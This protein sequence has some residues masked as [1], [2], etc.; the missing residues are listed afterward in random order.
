MQPTTAVTIVLSSPGDLVKE[1]LIVQYAIAKLDKLFEMK[2]VRISLR[3]W[4][5][6]AP[7]F[8]PGGLQERIEQELGISNCDLLIALFWRRYGKVDEPPYSRTAREVLAA[9]DSKRKRGKPEVMV[10][11]SRR[12]YFPSSTE[13]LREQIRVLEFKQEL[14]DAGVL[15]KDF[16]LS[17][18]G[19]MIEYDTQIYF[20]QALKTESVEGLT[21]SINCVPLDVRSEG[22]TEMTGA[23]QIDVTGTIS[24]SPMVDIIASL[25]MNVTN[26]MSTD[27]TVDA[28]VMSRNRGELGRGRIAGQ[29][30][31]LLFSGISL[32]PPGASI[33]DTLTIYGI[34]VDA[35]FLGVSRSFAP[36]KILASVQIRRTGQSTSTIATKQLDVAYVNPFTRISLAPLTTE[37]GQVEGLP[38]SSETETR[39]FEVTFQ[40]AFPGAFAPGGASPDERGTILAVALM[41]LPEDAIAL[42][43]ITDVEPVAPFTASGPGESAIAVQST[44][45]GSPL[46][47]LPKSEGARWRGSLPMY[48]IKAGL[49]I[50]E[51]VRAMPGGTST[52]TFGLVLLIPRSSL[53]TA[54][55]LAGSLAP[56]FSTALAGQP[57][58]TLPVPRFI[59]GLS[60][61]DIPIE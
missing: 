24:S 54:I 31:T 47:G 52:V 29:N 2:G 51:L 4:E 36:A 55:T 48:R 27:G 45:T 35:Q 30:N 11:F 39:L 19:E 33:N 44:A 57:S 3:K 22:Y 6:L 1:R 59:P 43:T 5:D 8:S 46:T 12:P 26:R 38:A 60:Q 13:E 42:A 37:R 61:F 40:A 18:L 16:D 17:K 15:T 9:M 25:S 58:A 14:R 49:A 28:I 53:P 34:R 56:F 23:I 50:W 10:Y 41:G 32:G 21:F 7:G 20:G